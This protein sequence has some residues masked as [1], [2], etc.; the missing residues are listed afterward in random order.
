MTFLKKY[1]ITTHTVVAAIIFL[2][3][4]YHNLPAV[5]AFAV[6]LWAHV[7]AIA[8]EGLSALAAIVML[9]WQGRKEW[10]PEERA[11]SKSEEKP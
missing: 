2:I 4:A 5:H 7:P 8:K 6:T 11:D 10:T 1:N 3:G 9:Y